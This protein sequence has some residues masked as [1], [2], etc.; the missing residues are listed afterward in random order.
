MNYTSPMVN[1][2][3]NSGKNNDAKSFISK[4]S[5]KHTNCLSGTNVGFSSLPS[6]LQKTKT[7]V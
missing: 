3:L 4:D 2:D 7:S 5:D 1:S 6:P